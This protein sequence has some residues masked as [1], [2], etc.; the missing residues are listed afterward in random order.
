MMTKQC[1]SRFSASLFGAAFLVLIYIGYGRAQPVPQ[2]KPVSTIA[3]VLALAG[4]RGARVDYTRVHRVLNALEPN[5]RKVALKRLIESR[6]EELSVDIALLA[7]AEPGPDFVEAIASRI[8]GWLPNNQ[9][10]ILQTLAPVRER[11]LQV[12]RNLVRSTLQDAKQGSD[13]EPGQAAIEPLG[14]SAILLAGTRD[15]AD[16]QMI[17]ELAQ[18]RPRLW[19]VWMA[20]AY[21]AILDGPSARLASSTYQ[22]GDVPLPV[23]VAAASALGSVDA[24]AATFAAREIRT[25]L[26]GF[27]GREW[28]SLMKASVESNQAGEDYRQFWQA[29]LNFHLA[30]ALLVLRDDAAKPLTT[31]FLEANN[32]L[33]R[34]LCGI[35]AARRWPDRILKSGQGAFSEKEYAALLALIAQDHPDQTAAA[36]ALTPGGL[37]KAQADLREFGLG[38]FGIPGTLLKVF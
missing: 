21:A 5:D 15:K 11:F 37:A 14:M 27:A 29:R 24:Q 34:N 28:E 8:V 35:V 2:A 32:Q 1:G 22:R 16:Y 23:R 10:A 26:E 19:G 3:D 17:L 7:I 25:F 36:A 9:A 38:V 6:N 12:P 20:V 13:P 18:L 4:E 30:V 31:H 33:V